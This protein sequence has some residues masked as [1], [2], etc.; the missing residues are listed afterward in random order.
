MSDNKIIENTIPAMKEY[1]KTY[2]KKSSNLP[3]VKRQDEIVEAK[4]S[5]VSI[6]SGIFLVAKRILMCVRPSIKLSVRQV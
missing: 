3:A 2:V 6:E 4:N 1:F 5:Q